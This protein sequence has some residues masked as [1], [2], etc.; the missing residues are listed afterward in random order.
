MAKQS[1]LLLSSAMVV[2]LLISIDLT[3]AACPS[4]YGVCS[5]YATKCCPNGQVCVSS[6]YCCPTGG[7]YLC[8]TNRCCPPNYVG[9]LLSSAGG[10]DLSLLA[11]VQV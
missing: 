10:K 8:Q 7:W 5:N 11:S 2:L 6:E 9:K 4:G 3:S 1:I